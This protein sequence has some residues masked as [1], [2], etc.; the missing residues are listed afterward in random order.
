MVL[1]AE[2]A[3]KAVHG[4]SNVFDAATHIRIHLCGFHDPPPEL[5]RIVRLSEQA[6]RGTA[7]SKRLKT[8]LKDAMRDF[9]HDRE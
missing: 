3:A 2:S 1:A 9:L 4:D 8:E 5:D 7:P 6:E